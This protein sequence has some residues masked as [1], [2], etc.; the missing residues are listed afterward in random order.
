[1]DEKRYFCVISHTHWDRE[2]YMPFEQFR[3]RLVELMDRLIDIITEYPAYIFHLDAQTIVLEDYLEIRPWR[4]D[5]L[6]KLITEGNILVGPWYLQNDFYLTSGE[7]TIRN[8]LAGTR[9]ADEFGRCTRIGYAPDQF[10]NISQLPQILNQFGVDNFIFGRGYGKYLF[11]ENGDSI[12]ND[13]GSPV[14]EKAP[15][16]FIWE[17]ADGSKLLAVHMKYWYN[18]AQRIYADTDA[19]ALLMDSIKNSFDGFAVTPYLLLMNGVD[20]L[21]A[22][23]DLIPVISAINSRLKNGSEILQYSMDRYIADLKAYI[24]KEDIGLR[25]YSG[26]LRDGHDWEILK[27]TLSSRVYLKQLNCRAQ[28]GLESVLEPMSA[29][30]ELAGAD[31]SYDND[32]LKYLWKQLLKNHPHDSI[33]GCSRDEVHDHMEDNYAKLKE[34]AGYLEAKKAAD[35]AAHAAINTRNPEDNIICLINT[36]AREHAGVLEAEAVFLS[37]EQVEAFDLTDAEGNPVDFAVIGVEERRFDVFTALNLPGV[38]DVKAFRMLLY[39]SGTKGFSVKGLKVAK[40]GRFKDGQM[41]TETAFFE[42]AQFPVSIG[43]ES[44]RVSAD[45][46]GMVTLEFLHDGRIVKNAIL[47]EDRPDCGDSYVFRTTG[48]RPLYSSGFPAKVSASEI[49]GLRSSIRIEYAMQIPAEYDFENS[50]RSAQTVECPVILTLTL[51]RNSKVLKTAVS[52]DNRAKDHRLRLLVDTGIR[53]SASF[54]DIPFDII[55]HGI[56]PECPLTHS[57]VHPNTSFAGIEDGQGGMAVL[58]YGNHE[59]EH[60]DS[61]WNANGESGNA[62][63]TAGGQPVS[64]GSVLA[65]TLVRGNRFIMADG[66]GKSGGGPQWDVPGNQCL[67]PITGEFGI[68]AFSGDKSLLADEA[69]AFR[70]P[71]K[72]VF[73]SCNSKK[74]AGGRFAMQGSTLNEF[75]YLPDLHPALAIPDN[76]PI[77]DVKGTS[78]IVSA[79][80]KSHDGEGFILRLVNRSGSEQIASIGFAGSITAGSMNEDSG[81]VLK[82]DDR[83]GA[84]R[85]TMRAKEIATFHLKK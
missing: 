16:E 71:A 5:L 64:S 60:L 33:C 82:V 10:G 22:Q 9:M 3:A 61:P 11:D 83:D 39:D 4:R 84:V 34:A 31:R 27:G 69:L 62:T 36:M 54:G 2:W 77:V 66:I 78:I 65:F 53:S 44:I 13:D 67:R 20:H 29:M 15:T 74:F 80:K 43:N 37:S 32:Y 85:V 42:H 38:L 70:V 59:Y 19:A 1:M 8:L 57:N 81:A 72:A 48:D 47:I 52:F 50:R 21:E 51:D 68:T 49:R 56:R 55:V 35:I 7:A 12:R 6:K 41:R 28:A 23:N 76:Q 14:R 73:A 24:A 30:Y 79:L 18:N 25:L 58:T 26:E 45:H 75:Y 63:D 17:G 40:T 46:L